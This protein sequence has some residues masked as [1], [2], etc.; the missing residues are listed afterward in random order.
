MSIPQPGTH[1]WG[2]QEDEFIQSVIL[3][4]GK[5]QELLCY[6]PQVYYVIVARFRKCKGLR[7]VNIFPLAV[8]MSNKI[9]SSSSSSSSSLLEVDKPQLIT[10][11]S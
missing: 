10:K 3:F 4:K 1:Q 6:L 11:I 9:T 2:I 7:R 5:S 8:F